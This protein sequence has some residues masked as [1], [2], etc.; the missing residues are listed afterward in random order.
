MRMRRATLTMLA[1]GTLLPY[2][3]LASD[4]VI[5]TKG[6][7][8]LKPAPKVEG[9]F[10]LQQGK[11]PRE[12]I[13]AF[14][15][16]PFLDGAS[17]RMKWSELEPADEQFD[18]SAVDEILNEVKAFNER[19]PGQPP[20]TFMLRVMAGVHSPQWFESAGVRYYDTH[21]QGVNQKKPQ[22]LHIPMPYENP[23]FLKQLREVYQAMLERYKDDPLVVMYHGT[24]SAGPWDEIFHPSKGAPLPPDYSPQK[25]IDGMKEQLD[26]LIDEISLKGKPAELPWSG[27]QPP[28]DVQGP[29]RERV[30]ERLGRRSPFFY[31]QGNG[32][33]ANH[34]WIPQPNK[35]KE[36]FD[37]NYGYQAVGTN[38]GKGWIPQG[39]WIPLVRIAQENHVPYVEIYP[40]RCHARR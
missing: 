17:I 32:W 31:P 9:V 23:E 11:W 12:V 37:L 27:H 35:G 8:T 36:V 1:L 26:V 16:T 6:G 18:W 2:L 22:P 10:L 3:A 5:L 40:P 29:L 20:R 38:A 25:F 21:V 39:D 15:K 24:W 28:F 7:W 33:G 4:N 34:K 14:H 13:D 30:V 19:N